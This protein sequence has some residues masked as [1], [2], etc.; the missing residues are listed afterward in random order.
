MH[1]FA[2]IV[3]DPRL[4]AGSGA[5]PQWIGD[6]YRDTLGILAL[7]CANA[8]TVGKLNNIL[9]NLVP[10]TKPEGHLHTLGSGSLS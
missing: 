1:T 5:L 4:L 3:L 9:E 2:R 6:N 8:W 10:G 7:M